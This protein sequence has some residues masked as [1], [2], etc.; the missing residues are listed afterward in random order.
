VVVVE[1]N[2]YTI[3]LGANLEGAMADDV[4]IWPEGCDRGALVPPLS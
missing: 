4:T 2:G 3:E 1:V